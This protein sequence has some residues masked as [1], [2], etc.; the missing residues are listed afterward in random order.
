MNKIK[1]VKQKSE[2][3]INELEKIQKNFTSQNNVI[4]L[5]ENCFSF[6]SKAKYKANLR[7]G[8]KLLTPK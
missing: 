5:Y 2:K 1:K 7:R 4:K 6:V 3:Q 8:L